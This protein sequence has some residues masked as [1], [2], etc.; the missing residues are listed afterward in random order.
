MTGIN[1]VQQLKGPLRRVI[2]ALLLGAVFA[3][4]AEASSPA[5]PQVFPPAQSPGSGMYSPIKYYWYI[6]YMFSDDPNLDAQALQ[7]DSAALIER[8]RCNSIG[9]TGGAGTE[10]LTTCEV[11]FRERVASIPSAHFFLGFCASGQAC[12]RG[13]HVG[14]V[15]LEDAISPGLDHKFEHVAFHRPAS[16]GV[17]STAEAPCK[18][19]LDETSEVTSYQPPDSTCAAA[20]SLIAAAETSAASKPLVTAADAFTPRSAACSRKDAA[21]LGSWKII[22]SKQK[23]YWY[24]T[25]AQLNFQIENPTDE[26]DCFYSADSGYVLDEYGHD[27]NQTPQ[28]FYEASIAFLR[29]TDVYEDQALLQSHLTSGSDAM[30]FLFIASN[31]NSPHYGASKRG[32]IG[33]TYV[34][35]DSP[36]TRHAFSEYIKQK[37]PVH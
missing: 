20:Q 3:L 15:P 1:S 24:S 8:E 31:K 6:S 22:E 28:Y 27:E 11:A 29:D 32:C 17:Y 35:F 33:N 18:F 23:I 14:D 4:S 30:S 10:Y 13:T 25:S 36:E 34:N 5:C 9:A 7:L 2:V 21:F 26:Y 37:A 19:Y 12:A 16:L